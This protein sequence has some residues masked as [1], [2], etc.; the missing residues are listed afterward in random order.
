MDIFNFLFGNTQNGG[1]KA[2]ITKKIKNIDEEEAIK[3]YENLK[4]VNLKL[5][6][7]ETR[8]GNKFVDHFTFS[9]RLETVSKKGMTYFDIIKKASINMLPY[10]EFLNYIVVLLDYLNR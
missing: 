1:Q 7:N 8:I 3:D 9:E 4:K 5:V 6:T 10:I 2:I